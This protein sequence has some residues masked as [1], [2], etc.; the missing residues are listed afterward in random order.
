MMEKIDA[1]RYLSKQLRYAS[2]KFWITTILKELVK[3]FE[4]FFVD[5]LLIKTII[6]AL[7]EGTDIWKIV[8]CVLVAVF[9]RAIRIIFVSYY[10]NYV[11][12]LEPVKIEE[13]FTGMV[14]D[15]SNRVDMKCYDEAEY[16][17]NY[18]MA[19]QD[20]DKKAMKMI[21]DMG[22]LIGTVVLIAL[23]GTFVLIK[24][25]VLLI[26]VIIPV[27]GDAILRVK[28]SNREYEKEEKMSKIRRRQDYIN[29]V[30]N[31]SGYAEEVRLSSITGFFHKSFLDNMEEAKEVTN[32]FF[33]RLLRLYL[34][35]DFLY[36][37]KN[38]LIIIY[39]AYK[40][41]I[42]KDISAGDFMAIQT[43][44]AGFSSNLGK[45]TQ[46]TTVFSGHIL[47]SLRF[48]SFLEYQNFVIDGTRSLNTIDSIEFKN[49]S[50]RYAQNLPLVLKG[51]NL[52]I[53]A[54][55]Q[56][57]LVGRNGQGKSTLIKLLL[58]FYDVTEGEILINGNPIGQYKMDDLRREMMFLSQQFH[59]YKI[60]V[61]SNIVLCEKYDGGE[62]SCDFLRMFDLDEI[63]EKFPNREY[64][65]LGKDLY[66]DGI[67][68][69]KGQQQ[70]VA[71]CRALNKEG[72]L[73]IM[74]EPTAALDS[75]AE[76]KLLHALKDNTEKK[77]SIIISHNLSLTKHAA[78]IAV[79]DKGKIEEIGS[80]DELF[81][82]D[83]IYKRMFLLQMKAALGKES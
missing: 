57:A 48:K 5:V 23:T 61:I 45:I 72:S 76:T 30:N 46:R 6:D 66:K 10:D 75:N 40:A 54:G 20:I 67:E 27:I 18:V 79:L 35:S 37:P 73:L 29:K 42:V 25:P 78:Q 19:V 71:I 64:S 43:A 63:L 65:V 60:P 77:I 16:Y 8:R 82:K 15:K 9:I 2:I 70:R 39:L 83:G 32:S 62:E 4:Y 55:E 26:F 33:C 59:C 14:M 49:V 7:I 21:D 12:T 17:N 74:D 28:I 36:E 41:I 38:L 22:I 31:D 69:S 13:Y 52:K 58:R 47:H 50:F 53:K 44:L 34:F 24:D 80:H 56:L 1:I 81:T 68:L 3:N 11:N 51:I